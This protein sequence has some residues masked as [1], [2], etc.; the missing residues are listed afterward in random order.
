[1][2][3]SDKNLKISACAINLNEQTGYHPAHTLHWLQEKEITKAEAIS[4]QIKAYCNG[5]K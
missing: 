4:Q 3:R 5:Q 1:M 2:Q